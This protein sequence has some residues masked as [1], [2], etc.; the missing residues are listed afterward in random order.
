M[1]AITDVHYG[2]QQAT[3]ACVVGDWSAEIAAREWTT[4]TSPIAEYQPGEFYKR[5]LPCLVD[6]LAQADLDEL[7]AIVIDGYVWL[8]GDSREGLGAHL[9]DALD[10]LVPIVGVAK[11][12]FGDCS[13]ATPVKRGDSERPLFVT[14]AGMSQSAAA[15]RVEAMHG[16][17]RVPTLLRRA[18]QL[19][20]GG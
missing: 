20:R 11:N 12:P 3:A 8:D 19:C 6:V 17:Y 4:T 7:E 18:D 9:W 15:A 10:R 16:P 1:I 13:F 5:E 14:A 2:E